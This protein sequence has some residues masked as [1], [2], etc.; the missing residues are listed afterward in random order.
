M[1]GLDGFMNYWSFWKAAGCRPVLRLGYAQHL[2]TFGDRATV[3]GDRHCL[4]DQPV[5]D[6]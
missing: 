5:E 2:F 6:C 4:C 3:L 1:A